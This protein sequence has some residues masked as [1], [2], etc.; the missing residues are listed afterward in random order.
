MDLETYNNILRHR[1][2]D[3]THSP[4]GSFCGHTNGETAFKHDLLSNKV[5][6]YNDYNQD[7]RA[8][9]LNNHPCLSICN[10]PREHP[11]TRKNRRAVLIGSLGLSATW[12]IVLLYAMHDAG[13]AHSENMNQ[14]EMMEMKMAKTIMSVLF[15]L[16]KSLSNSLL[17]YM[18]VC[19]CCYKESCPN[20]CRHFWNLVGRVIAALW[21]YVILI[22]LLASIYMAVQWE[23]FEEFVG[24]FITSTLSGWASSWILLQS[25]FRKKWNNEKA[26]RKGILGKLKVTYLEYEEYKRDR[27]SYQA[28][29]LVTV[30][31]ADNQHTVNL[32]DAGAVTTEMQQISPT[33]NL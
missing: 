21:M 13:Y 29:V 24:P 3:A 23:I 22:Y 8:Y 28:P 15:G 20:I 2:V 9:I 18:M 4:R 19:P 33:T 16:F 32:V 6:W 5:V 31:H 11:Y 1:G 14:E 17:K 10:V 25:K 30:G 12:A 26:N 7:R 27:N